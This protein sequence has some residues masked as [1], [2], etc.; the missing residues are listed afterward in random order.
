[1]IGAMLSGPSAFEFLLCLIALIVWATVM[2]TSGSLD[3]CLMFLRTLLNAFVGLVLAA[4][5]NWELNLLAILLLFKY[6]VELKE[7][8]WF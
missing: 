6:F 1:M 7:M 5:V 4:G 8:L 2:L 3:L